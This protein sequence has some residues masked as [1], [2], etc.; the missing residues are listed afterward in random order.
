MRSVDDSTSTAD[1]TTQ[2][3][4][5][6][7]KAFVARLPNFSK[8]L[9]HQESRLL[10]ELSIAHETRNYPA[11]AEAKVKS[12]P[13]LVALLEQLR[14]ALL[15]VAGKSA[16]AKETLVGEREAAE[17]ERE[18]LEERVNGMLQEKAAAAAAAAES[19]AGAGNEDLM[20]QI[21]AMLGELR[22]RAA[23]HGP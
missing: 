13:K 12:R 23:R 5:S 4:A 17:A 7:F 14:D 6:L 1:N 11:K 3:F 19:K 22:G 18:K 9:K 16:E 10:Q 21:R 15:S 2:R 20:E 8:E